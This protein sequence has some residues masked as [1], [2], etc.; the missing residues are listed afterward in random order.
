MDQILPS[1]IVER[2]FVVSQNAEL[3]FLSK[4]F[5]RISKL[6]KVRS[7]F[8][9]LQF[10][11]KF[12]LDFNSGLPAK[13]P[14]IFNSEKLILSLL[15]KS[16]KICQEGQSLFCYAIKNSWK[17][18]VK[19]LLHI[20]IYVVNSSEMGSF[21][22]AKP[23]IHLN[24]NHKFI[25]LALG[26][27]DIQILNLIL[28]S[29]KFLPNLAD[30]NTN[31]VKV[32]THLRIE[33]NEIKFE[34]IQKVV[35]ERR[36]D[37]LDLL[38]QNGLDIKKKEK[39]FI[40]AISNSDI[41]TIEYLIDKGGNFLHLD[42]EAFNVACR[43]GNSNILEY[44]ES[45]CPKVNL[46]TRDIQ[47]ISIK[48]GNV[49]AMKYLHSKGFISYFFNYDNIPAICKHNNT[50]LFD[51]LY[52]KYCNKLTILKLAL[53]HSTQKNNIHMISHLHKNY[54][55]IKDFVD[56]NFF[57]ICIHCSC[58]DSAA[59][60]IRNNYFS[61]S[62][63]VNME[64]LMFEDIYSR[65]KLNDYSMH[66]KA[67]E[68]LFKLIPLFKSFF[69]ASSNKGH[70]EYISNWESLLKNRMNHLLII[71][72]KRSRDVNEI[73][74]LIENG[75]D[76]HTG[77]YQPLINS[78][79]MSKNIDVIKYLIENGS[80]VNAQNGQALINACQ[81]QSNS[82]VIKY[83]ISN[84]A[85][86]HSQN[87]QSL[88]EVCFYTDNF[89]L[90]EFLIKNGSD[91]NSQN[92]QAL[93]NACSRF[94]DLR[95][96]KYLID[97]GVDIHS[98]NDQAL[99]NL[100]FSYRTKGIFDF[101]VQ[102]GANIRAQN[103]QTLINACSKCGNLEHIKY[104][105]ENG[106]DI[107]AQLGQPLI[108]ACKIDH[109]IKVIKYLIEGGANVNSQNGQALINFCKVSNK[110]ENLDVIKCMVRNGADINAQNGQALI[111]ACSFRRNLPV[112]KYLVENGADV[113][114]QN[115]KAF[116]NACKGNEY[117]VIKFLIESGCEVNAQ[118]GQ[119]LINMCTSG[120]SIET[121]GLLF[122]NGADINA[123]NGQPL[124]SLCNKFILFNDSFDES[125]KYLLFKGADINA[126]KRKVWATLFSG[127]P[128]VYLIGYLIQ[129]ESSKNSQN[130]VSLIESFSFQIANPRIPYNIVECLADK[131]SII[132]EE[133]FL[134]SF[135]RN[136]R[137]KVLQ[138]FARK[139]IEIIKFKDFILNCIYELEKY[140]SNEHCFGLIKSPNM[141]P[142]SNSGCIFCHGQGEECLC[143]LF[144]GHVSLL[145]EFSLI[146]LYLMKIGVE[147]S[148]SELQEKFGKYLHQLIPIDLNS[149]SFMDNDIPKRFYSNSG[150]FPLWYSDS[151]DLR[152]GL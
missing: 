74:V 69:A 134:I 12:V 91:I 103:D 32:Q 87:N 119:P 130:D 127:C 3:R 132:S 113:N 102:N 131:M 18:V 122:E 17:E 143:N 75:A 46:N 23:L 70:N 33:L 9:L 43:Y 85:N 50:Q 45:H 96:I 120:R 79:T 52:Q 99:I 138:F 58:P 21:T 114:L 44:M 115:S 49:E 80:D 7:E 141:I 82:E 55:D 67:L 149:I 150:D 22:F 24:K 94:S 140:N 39:I 151:L 111:N 136:P 4:S 42:N 128:S 64:K 36:I 137:F 68:S 71:I 92:G 123:Q 19:F 81:N 62:E 11:K 8:F 121:L 41:Q 118:N 34:Y 31:K 110:S 145:D 35:K 89:E 78:C 144:Y 86:L 63:M 48:Y 112:I 88:I 53:L 10:G 126:Q 152:R 54:P 61:F 15:K 20:F 51:Y 98:Q 56:Q 65:F 30:I 14:K 28:N 97:N 1:E 135:L 147:F 38:F 26:V 108:S 5:Y 93:I 60:Y 148:T 84:G 73:K 66:T 124:I 2:L 100:F 72:S 105:I 139:G 101:L 125:F 106:A 95:K 47:R 59:F 109:N 104:M 83:L 40:P 146:I 27:L 57:L 116:V 13:F 16:S 90:F 117:D 76:I 77:N 37:V 129:S 133:N 142:W 25:E 107:N 6:T 29:Y